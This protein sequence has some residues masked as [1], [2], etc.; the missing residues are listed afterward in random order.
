MRHIKSVLM[1]PSCSPSPSL[2][3]AFLV[4]EREA[5]TNMIANFGNQVFATVMDSYNYK[6]ALERVVPSVAAEHVAAG[7]FWVLRPDSGVPEDAVVAALRAAESAFG[8]D[9]NEKGYK[10][11]RG[12][13]VI[14]GDGISAERINTI[15]SAVHAAG[16]SI[17]SVA[18]GMGGGLLQ[19]VH[20]DTMSFAVKL[21]HI[22]YAENGAAVDVMKAPQDDPGKDS[23]PGRL[24]VR[25]VDGIPTVFPWEEVSQE[26]NMLQVVYDCGPVPEYKWETFDELR[27]RVE[28]EWN[29]IP[30]TSQVISP[31]LSEKRRVLGEKIRRRTDNLSI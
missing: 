26:E 25:R 14:Q 21:N 5:I 30:P 7:G 19:K 15:V 13:G 17:Q 2:P 11:P 3:F 8:V 12:V 10:I 29:S 18:F 27:K 28:W 20:R 6:D 31:T 4:E 24:G 9:I 16:F 22:V 1:A 23:L